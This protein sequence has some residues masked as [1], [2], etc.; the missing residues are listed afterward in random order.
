LTLHL[1]NYFP[2]LLDSLVLDCIQ[3]FLHL[4]NFFVLLG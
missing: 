4:P 1:L 3:Y 2:V